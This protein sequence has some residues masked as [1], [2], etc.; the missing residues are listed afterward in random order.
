MRE[1]SESA[2]PL[3]TDLMW[4]ACSSSLFYQWVLESLPSPSITNGSA[5]CCETPAEPARTRQ[6]AAMSSAACCALGRRTDRRQHLYLQD[7]DP[8]RGV[9]ET[10]LPFGPLLAVVAA[11]AILGWGVPARVHRLSTTSVL[12]AGRSS[13]NRLRSRRSA[14]ALPRAPPLRSAGVRRLRA[15]DVLVRR[16]R[17]AAVRR[18][19]SDARLG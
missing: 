9:R 6:R 17:G 3:V 1:S 14:V 10:E 11:T 13:L 15:L 19:G 7:P 2:K 8:P 12:A 18:T 4:V 16:G 5:R